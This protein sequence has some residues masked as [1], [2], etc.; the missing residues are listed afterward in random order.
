MLI[1]VVISNLLFFYSLFLIARV[2]IEFI[3]MFARD[4]HPTG[5]I[6]VILEFIFTITDPPIKFLRKFIPPIPLGSVRL[7]LSVLIL[8]I[9]I[10]VLQ[11]VIGGII[12]SSA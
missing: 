11:S 6:V 9:G 4:W 5:A 12:A 1:L 7:D 8:L 10:M 2:V 3:R